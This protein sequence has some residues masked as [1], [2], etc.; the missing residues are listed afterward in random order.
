MN[1][2][3]EVL[4]SL[5]KDETEELVELIDIAVKTAGL[6]KAYNAGVLYK[7][8]QASVTEAVKKKQESSKH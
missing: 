5:N 2:Q 3:I 8:I 7:K 6:K 1:D 4:L